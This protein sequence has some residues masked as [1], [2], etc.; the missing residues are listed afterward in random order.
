MVQNGVTLFIRPKIGE[1]I[2]H[3]LLVS[4]KTLFCLRMNAR[5]RVCARVCVCA[6][7]RANVYEIERLRSVEN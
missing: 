4:S 3:F 1:R 2:T 6:R 5:V 7:A